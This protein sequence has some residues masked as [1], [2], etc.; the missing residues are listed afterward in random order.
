MKHPSDLGG[1]AAQASTSRHRSPGGATS[2]RP[3]GDT[4]RAGG[5]YRGAVMDRFGRR[6]LHRPHRIPRVY[7][8][9]L[10]DTDVVAI[11]QP[12]VLTR[13]GTA[14]G[15]H[16]AGVIA[17]TSAWLVSGDAETVAETVWTINNGRHEQESFCNFS[18]ASDPDTVVTLQGFQVL[19][20]DGHVLPLAL[21]P[22]SDAAASIQSQ[23]IPPT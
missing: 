12:E 4:R 18:L 7:L 10:D 14:R 19:M 8:D 15:W 23:S 5:D 13:T 11:G 3:R 2:C 21:S 16:Q 6:L 22:S 20:A 9:E 1:L 17:F